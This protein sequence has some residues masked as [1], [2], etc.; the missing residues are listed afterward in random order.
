MGDLLDSP[1]A[2]TSLA[3]SRIDFTARLCRLLDRWVSPAVA[4]RT[5]DFCQNFTGLF[6]NAQAFQFNSLASSECGYSATAADP[7]LP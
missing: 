3:D 7:F 6:Q 2:K 1:F 5:Y 4:G